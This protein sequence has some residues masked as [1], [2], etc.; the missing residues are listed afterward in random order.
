M[1][2]TITTCTEMQ[3]IVRIQSNCKE[4]KQNAIIITTVM[5]YCD[6]SSLF[7][8][9]SFVLSLSLAFVTFVVIFRKVHV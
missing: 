9:G 2:F 5:G 7:V 1:K 6:H 8:F 3:R 4:K